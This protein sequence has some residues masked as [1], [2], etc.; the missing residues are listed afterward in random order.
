MSKGKHPI[1]VVLIILGVIVIFLGTLMTVI[2]KMF[3]PSQGF[4]FG[5]RIGVIPI[6]GVI[7]D[8]GPILAQLVNFKKDKRLKAII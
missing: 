6:K 3:G 8:S 5:D 1:L 4:A 2:L 7:S